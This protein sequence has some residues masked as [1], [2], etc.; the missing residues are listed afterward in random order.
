MS[1]KIL[2]MTQNFYP[3]IGSSGNRNK[4]LYQLLK[5]HGFDVTV[6][7][8]EPAYPNK[9]LYQDDKFWDDP[10]LNDNSD[11]IRVKLSSNKFESKILGRLFFYLEIAYLFRKKLRQI[12]KSNEFDYIIIS[13]PPIFIFSAGALAAK[14]FN[15]KMILDVRDLWPDTLTGIKK[16]HFKPILKI[17]QRYEKRMYNKADE[18][19]INSEGFRKHIESKMKRKKTITFIPN[20]AREYEL[21]NKE[22]Q[23][24]FSVIYTGNLGLAQDVE[25]IQEL[26]KR[27]HNE[28]IKFKVI[29]YGYKANDF[30]QF[31]KDNKLT[32]VSITKPTTRNESL[33]AIKSCQVAVAFLNHEEVFNT[34]LPGKIIDYIT[35]RTPVI[36]SVDGQSANL[37]EQH[38][39]GY[40][41]RDGDVNE[42]VNRIKNVRDNPE[43]R[44]QM[45]HNCEILLR[46]Y[47]LWEQNIKKLVKL[48]K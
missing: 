26:A 46:K 4:N 32:N 11:I 18:I 35:C 1:K 6:L 36:A 25:K 37:I 27:L 48:L 23:D 40:V 8:T 33:K 9:N 44:S 20:G 41:A 39:V 47:F 14:L 2:I 3:V 34:V 30:I 7:T 38:E 16:L 45:Q 19:V 13:T 12:K 21:E 43:K 29:G 17:F 24:E 10:E 31:V 15:A 28:N 22:E 5:Q 42:I